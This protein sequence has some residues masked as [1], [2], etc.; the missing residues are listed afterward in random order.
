MPD[1]K[2]IRSRDNSL[3]KLVSRLQSS[4]SARRENGLFVLEGLRLCSDAFLNGIRFDKLIVSFSAAG[5][6][7]NEISGFLSKTGECIKVPDNLFEKIS[8]TKSPQ[9]II[10][11]C[12]IPEHNARGISSAGRYVALENISDPSNFG[13]VARTAE[14]GILCGL[15]L[16]LGLPGE[17]REAIL[18]SADVVSQ[19]PVTTLKLHQLQVI[20]G[21]ALARMFG[22]DGN[23]VHVYGL[24]EYVGLVA[25][26]IERVRPDIVMDRFVSQSPSELLV[27]PRWGVKNHEFTA[28]LT[29]EMKRRSTCQGAKYS[30]EQSPSVSL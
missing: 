16:I 21:T 13:A 18:Q 25:D 9:G 28:L 30:G 14:R 7:N 26:F 23:V 1:F 27:A 4:S 15:H 24:Q 17:G 6:Y 5:K 2:E 29:A 22:E 19:L 8:D 11:L 12:R 10:A 3:I 20:R